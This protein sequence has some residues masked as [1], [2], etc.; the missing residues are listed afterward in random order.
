MNIHGFQFESKTLLFIRQFWLQTLVVIDSKSC[1]TSFPSFCA[2]SYGCAV[3][4]EYEQTPLSLAGRRFGT[5]TLHKIRFKTFL[6]VL[7][8]L[9]YLYSE[10]NKWLHDELHWAL[11]WPVTKFREVHQNSVSHDKNPSSQLSVCACPTSQPSLCWTAGAAWAL[12]L[13]L[14]SK[15]S[16]VFWN[17]ILK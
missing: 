14:Q 5:A 9:P 13:I 17:S 2:Q 10:T 11:L 1:Q 3:L 8:L 15:P 4:L 16:T 6:F 7:V 12:P